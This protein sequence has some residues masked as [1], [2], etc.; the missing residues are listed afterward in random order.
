[1]DLIQTDAAI[2]PGNSG[3]ALVNGDGDVVGINVAYLPPQVGSV[4]IGFAI[5][6]ATVVDVV[7]Q[8]LER[9][10]VRH[11]ILGRLR[12]RTPGERVRVTIVRG[13]DERQVSAVLGE[14]TG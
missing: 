3:G 7:D 5:P 10:R 4:S 14:R 13:S 1:M 2:S 9:G 12:G 8:I 6:A 11:P